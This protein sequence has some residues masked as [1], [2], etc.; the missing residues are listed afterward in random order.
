MLT[1]E[2]LLELLSEQQIDILYR[3]LIEIQ[4]L[5]VGNASYDVL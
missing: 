2:R 1:L 4:E 3:Y 5:S